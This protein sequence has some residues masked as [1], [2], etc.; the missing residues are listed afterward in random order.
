MC[1]GNSLRGEVNVEGIGCERLELLHIG[2]E[3]RVS[4]SKHKKLAGSYPYPPVL[5][6]QLR[7]WCAVVT[8]DSLSIELRWRT[9]ATQH[10]QLS[11]S[12]PAWRSWWFCRVS[13]WCAMEV[14]VDFFRG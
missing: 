2:L 1:M 14:F 10:R 11:V 4:Y 6:E 13:I 8:R 7:G 5:D 9:S 3:L 12:F